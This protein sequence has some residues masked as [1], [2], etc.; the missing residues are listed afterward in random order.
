MEVIST[1][2][3]SIIGIIIGLLIIKFADK[4]ADWMGSIVG[5]SII[6]D[7]NNPWVYKILGFLLAIVSFIQF[8]M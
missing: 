6:R 4:I 1:I 5:N 8:F 3:D 7:T 2:F